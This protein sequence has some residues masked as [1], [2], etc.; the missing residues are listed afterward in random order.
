MRTATLSSDGVYC[1]RTF[2]ILTFIHSPFLKC[3]KSSSACGSFLSRDA[4]LQ[5]ILLILSI[6]RS[7]GKKQLTKSTMSTKRNGIAMS[8][9][10]PSFD[11][12][13]RGGF[14]LPEFMSPMQSS[15]FIMPFFDRSYTLV[16]GSGE[17]VL[18]KDSQLLLHYS[19]MTWLTSGSHRGP[20]FEFKNVHWSCRGR[21]HPSIIDII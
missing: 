2:S 6:M 14:E 20:H 19:K 15:L 4:R 1:K 5:Q 16:G 21:C 12:N 9:S 11:S 13:W 10:E 17:I 18:C 7:Y 8:S 3:C